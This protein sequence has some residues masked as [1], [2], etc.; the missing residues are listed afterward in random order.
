MILREGTTFPLKGRHCHL[1]KQQCVWV[2]TN[3]CLVCGYSIRS[4]SWPTSGTVSWTS[5]WSLNSSRMFWWQPLLDF[6]AWDQAPW[7]LELVWWWRWTEGWG[8]VPKRWYGLTQA[9]P[10]KRK[11]G[12]M[13]WTWR[14][15]IFKLASAH[16][17]DELLISLFFFPSAK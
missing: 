9:T 7:L 11:W 12:L 15:V 1:C 13:R 10:R 14:V 6:L 5:A 4:H 3:G 16:L 2:M 8:P 17:R